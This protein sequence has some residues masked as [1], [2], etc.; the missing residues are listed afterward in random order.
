MIRFHLYKT[1]QLDTPVEVVRSVIA[2]G[3]GMGSD[4]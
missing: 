3:W 2:K 4:Y 1:S